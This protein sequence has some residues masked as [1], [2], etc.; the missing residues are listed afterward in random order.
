MAYDFSAE[1]SSGQTL[2]YKITSNEAPYTVELTSEYEY[3]GYYTYPVG[4][5]V[6]P[7]MVEYNNIT[8]SV[9]SIG[10]YAFQNC[11]ELTSVAISNSVTSI[12][13]GAFFS[14]RGLTSATIPNSVTNIGLSAFS[15]C[16]VL[17]SI[18]I[19]NSVT[20]IDE[21]AFGYCISLTTVNYNATNCTSMGR[22]FSPFYGCDALTTLNIGSNVT[23]IPNYAF[24]AC[25]GLTLIEIPNSVTNIGDQAFYECSGITSVTIGNSVTSIGY[26]AFSGCSGLTSITIPN[27]VTSIGGGAFYGCSGLSSVTI[28]NSVTNIGGQA[29]YEC[30]GL[31]IVNFNA[32]NCTSMGGGY[33]PFYGC[34]ALS[35]LNIGSNVIN[36]PDNAFYACSGLTLV[37]I[38]NSVTN[39]G[40]LAF[41]ECSG[42]TSVTIGTGV[43][44]IG[45]GAFSGCSGLSTVNFNA[46]NCTSMGTGNGDFPFYGCDA[47]TTL[48]IGEN[49]TNIP[50]NAF[51]INY[52]ERSYS[53]YY[54]GSIAQWCGITF[55]E[56]P[57]EKYD[58]Y[59]GNNLVTNLVIPETVSEIKSYAFCD[60]HSITTLSI[61]GTLRTIGTS[62]FSRTSLSSIIIPNSVERVGS[63]AFYHCENLAT[64]FFNVRNCD[65]SDE[66]IFYGCPSLSVV[67][68]GEDVTMLPNYMFY[69][70][71][72]IDTIY[73]LAVNPPE[74]SGYTFD[75]QLS[76]NIPVMVPCGTVSIYSEA[77]F[78]YNFRRIQQAPGCGQT[79]TI[80]VLSN[81][82]DFGS[83]SGSGIYQ[84]Q[85]Q[86]SLT[87]T[88]ETGY[89]FLYWS[90]G[91][92]ENPHSI[93]VTSDATYIATF[94]AENGID[95]S[96]VSK[97]TIFPNPAT[98]LLNITS[99]ET[100]SGIEI[101]NVMGQ[102]VKRME[103][104]SD[105]AVCDVEELTAGVYVVRIHAAKSD[106]STT[107][108][109]RRFVKE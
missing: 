41:G 37:E 1:C 32:T 103:G 18:T 80:T 74:L 83:V 13:E 36:I 81:N 57:F 61:P 20:S 90:D 6:I 48:N 93:T 64:V 34:D 53:V 27:S 29:F 70:S 49:V 99:S 84:E 96:A 72:S 75:P 24:Y 56:Y 23:N 100:I 71:F 89:T 85:T 44:N 101:V 108:S 68:M 65:E 33:S 67:T 51:Y 4:N 43:T 12:G 35:A 19:P 25:S 58:L 39:I 109:V 21:N 8:Y 66:G 52:E 22:G 14:C 7:E 11:P 42:I 60:A 102:V 98:D 82:N 47:L 9:I 95:E 28:P 46:T 88:P 59:I 91:S 73:S 3:G 31:T 55:G 105:N 40:D 50:T 106:T 54:S 45:Y 79:Y 17:T 30:S 5:L 107:L 2:Y 86:V 16:N 87:A 77:D 38:P 63:S 15:R 10:E 94:V 104:N 69:E 97:I 78:W 76:L 62:A 92:T 26:G